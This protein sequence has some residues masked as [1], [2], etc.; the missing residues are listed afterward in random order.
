MTLFDIADVPQAVW[1]GIAAVFGLVFGSFITALSYRLPRGESIAAGRSQCPSCKA[2]LR[3]R[4]LIP[5][6]SWALNKGACRV[7]GT[8]VSARYPATELLTAGIFAS[9]AWYEVRLLPLAILLAAAVLMITLAVIDL[10]HRRLPLVLLAPLGLLAA[11]FAWLHHADPIQTAITAAATIAVGL[12]LAAG[13]RAVLGTPL[14]GAGDVYA[15]FIGALFLPWLPFL[16]FVWL[17]GALALLFGIAWRRAAHDQLF[18]FGPAVFS[19]LW[20]TLLFQPDLV[21]FVS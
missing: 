14:V 4:D 13:T 17:A 3:S 9:A 15:L 16:I 1:I 7:C 11:A 19:A 10:E 12:V 8:R 2:V 6:V 21:G 20:V 18:P 5:V